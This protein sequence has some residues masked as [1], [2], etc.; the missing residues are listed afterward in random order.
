M[1]LKRVIALKVIALLTTMIL[2]VSAAHAYYSLL[3]NR[4][5]TRNLWKTRVLLLADG[6]KHLI[7]WDDRVAIRQMLLNELHGSD[8][9]LYCVLLK[10]GAP[11]VHTFAQGVPPRLLQ[12]RPPVSEAPVWEFQDSKGAVVYDIAAVIDSSGTVLRLGLKQAAIDDKLQPLFAAI[13]FIALIA[14]GVSSYLAIRIAR[15]TTREVDTLAAAITTYGELSAADG[16][17]VEAT[18][19]EITEL[20]SSFQ[21]LTARRKAAEMELA[22]LNAELEQRV[23]ERTAL[24]QAANGELDA[25]AYSVSHDLRAPLRGVEGFSC[26]LLEEYGAVLDET[27][28]D[29][30]T[31][32]RKG[33]IR[34]GRLID[35]LLKL[36]RITRTEINRQ[37]VEL[38]RIARGVIRELQMQEPDRPV[39]VRIASGMT[40]SA[41]PTLIRS[42]LEN[43]LGNAWKF[44]RHAERPVIEF[45]A[46]ERGGE[47]V[48]FV[49]DN[50]AGFNMEYASKLF[51]AFQR[52]HRQDEFEG[53]GIGLASVKRVLLMHAGRVWAEGAEGQGATIYFTLGE[54]D[55]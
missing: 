2:A 30:L 16:L 12:L 33:C 46:L 40:A 49:R 41:D 17:A 4:E 28:K 52:L 51:G 54:S 7:L 20:V 22:A 44:T 34:M 31:R 25:F 8:I 36:S 14:I 35:D 15:R 43:L 32:I 6:C 50:G 18:S 37:P 42:V 13:L 48:Y 24:L 9:L 23:A 19:T 26:A 55:T 38:D 21:T 5:M 29:Y 45:A 53:S 47:R 3:R 11:Y 27:G 1:Q 39:E 10:G